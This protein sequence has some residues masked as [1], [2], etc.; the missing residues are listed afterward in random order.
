M[1]KIAFVFLFGAI[2]IAIDC[3]AQA[4]P[5]PSGTA[6][7]SGWKSDLP[8]G[9]EQPP[10]IKPGEVPIEQ[11]GNPN[12]Q[13]S[14]AQPVP[15]SLPAAIPPPVQASPDLPPDFMAPNSAPPAY[16]SPQPAPAVP[17]AP[18]HPSGNAAAM[19]PENQAAP[20]GYKSDLPPEYGDV[21]QPK[22]GEVPLESLTGTKWKPGAGAVQVD[23]MRPMGIAPP[24]PA[25]LQPSLLGEEQIPSVEKE[26]VKPQRQP[27]RWGE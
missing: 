16:G 1:R 10:E 8:V 27:T 19:S 23:D 5:I 25:G 17:V 15:S 24:P 20:M 11:I 4:Q 22:P 6:E 3:I 12:Y 21:Y 18:V 14:Q 9:Y 26:N 13:P 2:F 7:A